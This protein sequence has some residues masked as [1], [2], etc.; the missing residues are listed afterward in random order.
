MS[1]EILKNL[2]E[3]YLNGTINDKLIAQAKKQAENIKQQRQMQKDEA[4]R[5][6]DAEQLEKQK[7]INRCPQLEKQKHVYMQEYLDYYRT[8]NL[9]ELEQY[10]AEMLQGKHRLEYND[11][12]N[13]IQCMIIQ[14]NIRKSRLNPIEE[15]ARLLRET[16]LALA[17][18]K[19][20]TQEMT[21]KIEETKKDIK[22]LGESV[23]PTPQDKTK[24]EYSR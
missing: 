8:Y 23:K 21:Q 16:K 24:L 22:N 12:D 11:P 6:H 10:L 20:Q 5:Q 13:A 4:K 2:T 9:D 1:E 18:T 15:K 17:E 19:M 14:I 3:G 7:P